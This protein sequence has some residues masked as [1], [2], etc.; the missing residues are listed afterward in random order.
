MNETL[1]APSDQGG[2]SWLVSDNNYIE[3][4]MDCT[5]QS[6]HLVKQ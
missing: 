5:P 1:S 4:E 3:K 6:A 2:L